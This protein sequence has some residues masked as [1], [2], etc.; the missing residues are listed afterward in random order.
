[1]KL[2]ALQIGGLASKALQPGVEGKLLGVTS[3]GV[4]LNSGD[5][6]FF[7]TAADYKSPY[8]I[9]VESL[10]PL[11]QRLVVGD[12]WKIVDSGIQ[13]FN[14]ELRIDFRNASIWSPDPPKKTE[15]DARTQLFRMNEIAGH[16][17]ELDS[18]K[19]WIFLYQC[20][21]PNQ[22]ARLICSLTGDFL[23]GFHSSDLS[24]CLESS[25]PILGRGGGLTPS[26]DDWL[27]GYLLFHT[28][29]GQAIGKEDAFIRNLGSSITS[30]AF[31]RTTKISANRIEAACLGWAEELFLKVIDSLCITDCEL[32][33]AEIRHLVNFGHSSGVDTCMGILSAVRSLVAPP[34]N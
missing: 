4:F 26:G 7:L 25:R 2:S 27:T 12:Q 22:E 18:S 33:D 24:R 32:S 20:D 14:E 29:R 1:M 11:T 5:K 13:F 16:M 19:G 6:I 28:R 3:S 30:L 9:Q 8:N 17:R 31:E 23:A 21:D 34:I 15:T 10:E